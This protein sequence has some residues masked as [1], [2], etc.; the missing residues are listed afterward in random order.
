MNTTINKGEVDI[1]SSLQ[2][3]RQP[4]SILLYRA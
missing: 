2:S 3:V 4:G 1:Q